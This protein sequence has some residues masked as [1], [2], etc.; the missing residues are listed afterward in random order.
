MQVTASVGLARAEAQDTHVTLLRNADTAMYAAKAQGPGIMSVYRAEMHT[1]ARERLA[2]QSQ[3]RLAIERGEIY[4]AYQPIVSLR[5]GDLVGVEALAR[6]KHP[7]EGDIPPSRFIPAAERCGLMEPLGLH[8]LRRAL[9]DLEGCAESWPD[10]RV[11][12][13]FLNTSARQLQDDEFI[14]LIERELAARPGLRGRLC[15]E[16]TESLFLQ[17]TEP[18]R[19]R[20]ERLRRLGVLIGIDDFGTGYSSLSYLHRIP[21][22]VLKI[23]REFVERLGN[24]DRGQALAES[25]VALATTMGLRTIGEGI[26]TPQQLHALRNLGCE[27]GQGYALARPAP[28]SDIVERATLGWWAES[29]GVTVRS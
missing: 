26:E 22:D 24:A 10:G 7:E 16:V 15:L 18:V 23:P 21:L 8:L 19:A 4:L 27:L 3:L 25:I 29:L 14:D 28:L 1:E 5:R 20:L 12:T 11:P 13:L 9:Q 2:L 6:W 17:N